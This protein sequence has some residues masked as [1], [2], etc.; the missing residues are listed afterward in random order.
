MKTKNLILCS[1]AL[2]VIGSAWAAPQ[3]AKTV[4]YSAPT[5]SVKRAIE[6]IAKLTG[7]KLEASPSMASEYVFIHADAMPLQELLNHLAQVTSGEWKTEGGIRYLTAS[8]ATRVAEQRKELQDRATQIRAAQQEMAKRLNPKPKPKPDPKAKGDEED[9]VEEEWVPGG[10]DWALTKLSAALD[11]MVLAGIP[12]EGRMVFATSPTSMQ[13]ALGGNLQP[14]IAKLVADHNKLVRE[15]K[16]AE[17]EME[18]DESQLQNE[19][20]MRAFRIG[21]TEDKLIE[22]P[23]AKIAVVVARNPWRG[24]STELRVY[25]AKGN[26]LA[27]ADSMIPVREGILGRMDVAEADSEAP[28]PEQKPSGPTTP[29]EFSPLTKELLGIF[30]RGGEG[31]IFDFKLS[32]GLRERL[33]RPD[34]FDPLSFASAE[35]L[36]AIAKA[37]KVQIVANIPDES[38][39]NMFEGSRSESTVEAAVAGMEKG[40]DVVVR[41][42]GDTMVIMPARPAEARAG[43]TNRGSLAKLIAACQSQPVVRL[44]D[45]AEYALKSPAPMRAP[46]S[47]IYLVL[48][49]PG[50]MKF[51]FGGATSWDAIRLYG[52]LGASQRQ[53]LGSGGRIPFAALTTDQSAIV[54]KM[55]YGSPTRLQVERPNDPPKDENDPSSLFDWAGMM[56]DMMGSAPTDYQDE[57]TEALP[58]GL[59]P[60]GFLEAKV[61]QGNIALIEGGGMMAMMMGGA[62]GPDEMAGLKFFTEDPRMAESAGSF[63]PKLDKFRVGDRTTI[64]LFMRYA[65]TISRKDTLHDDRVPKD[66][67]VVGMNGMPPAFKAQVDKRLALM[68]KLMPS[69]RFGGERSGVPP[70]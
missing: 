69:D 70:R 58:N 13:R 49:V 38:V 28:N 4:T 7:E 48:F 44:D 54:R 5:V 56:G 12:D 62:L 9:M 14:L 25:G 53:T 8:S 57:P 33:L 21:N 10:A 3:D 37:R 46:A 27:S 35:T 30:D 68:K 26:I 52:T 50:A 45:L 41:T 65:P 40:D 67:P 17:K 24:L 61:E 23:V 11:P 64:Q 55:T 51:A 60:S 29:I 34:Q 1:L 59:P 31:D 2:A 20:M 6:E 36:A 43:R 63:M 18:K 42:T 39:F 22:E 15:M 47:M 66:A 19:E 32:D 16:Q